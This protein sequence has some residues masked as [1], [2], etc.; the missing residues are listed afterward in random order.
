MGKMS[1]FQGGE[2]MTRNY[3]VR[4]WDDFIAD[5][6]SASGTNRLVLALVVVFVE[7]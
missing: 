3:D 6:Q 7:M 2:P 5:D 4:E 1:F